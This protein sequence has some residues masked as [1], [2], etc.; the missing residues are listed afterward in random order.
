MANSDKFRDMIAERLAR[1]GAIVIRPMFGGAGVYCGDTM[2]GLLED[3]VL[4]FR[5][6]DGNREEFIAAGSAPFTYARADGERV[7]MSYYR[8]PDH[9]L[10]DD[11]ELAAWAERALAAALRVKTLTKGGK[12]KHDV[13]G[14]PPRPD[15]GRGGP[16]F[17]V[18]GGPRRVHRSPR[19]R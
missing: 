13:K 11:D 15:R 7:A 17:N 1:L 2:F 5:V 10:D 3:D 12:P 19:S 4:Y 18:P 14:G 16:T 9:L 6:D 8:A